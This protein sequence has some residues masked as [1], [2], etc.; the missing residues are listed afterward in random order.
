[1]RKII[2]LLAAMAIAVVLVAVPSQADTTFV[3]DRTDDVATATA[4]TSAPD[5]C[6]LRGAIIAANT[7]PGADTITVPE[8][9]YSLTLVGAGEANSATG[10]LDIKEGLTIEGAGVASTIVD[11]GGAT[12]LQDRIF[13][14]HRSVSA[15][16]SGL[17]I[18]GG[19][20]SQGGGIFNDQGTLS[21]YNSIISSNAASSGGGIYNLEGTLSVSSST[22]RGNTASSL[23][24]GIRT[25]LGTLMVDRSTISGNTASVHGGGIF[26]ATDGGFTTSKTTITNSTISGNTATNGNGG[27]VYNEQGLTEM[28]YSTITN[29][30]APNGQGS[31]VASYGFAFR[32]TRVSSSIISANTN[33]DV[34]FVGGT[35]NS[36]TSGGYNLIGDGNATSA[37]NQAGDQIDI[38]DPGLKRLA[39]NAPGST[40]THALNATSPAI[41]AIPKEANGCAT[42]ITTDQTGTKRPQGV[43]CDIGSYEN[44]SPK[45]K[46]VSPKHGATEVGV[47]TKV[48]AFFSQG[49]QRDTVSTDTFK[50]FKEVEGTSSTLVRR[51]VTYDPDKKA[52]I[53]TPSAPLK[54]GATYKAVVTTAVRDLA[55]NALDQDRDPTNGN[56]KKEWTFTVVN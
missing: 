10:D 17:T 18:T 50:L 43:A 54:A 24:G 51:E 6:S 20:S 32:E 42:T 2:L 39:L 27:G 47:G 23:G 15:T 37:F 12:G 11:G 28:R 45:V 9:T 7:A 21:V 26:S 30:T 35:T 22:I 5:D 25:H 52:A 36:F 46:G 44:K 56:Q 4:C 19:S 16:I 53:L 41:N 34:D 8:G 1:M 48:R 3:V 38:A 29:N 49:I 13:H 40:K 33:T 55:G 14:N 31:G